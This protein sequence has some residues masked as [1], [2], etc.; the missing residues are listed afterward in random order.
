MSGTA[1]TLMRRP[2]FV[3]IT[4]V[5][6]FAVT[7]KAH[8]LKV[9]DAVFD[10]LGRTHFLVRVRFLKNGSVSTKRADHDHTEHWLPDTPITIIKGATK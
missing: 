1:R 2:G 3:D 4:E 6:P 8:E 7:V 9:G 10:T 5:I